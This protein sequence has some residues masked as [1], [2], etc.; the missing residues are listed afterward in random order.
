MDTG[1]IINKISIR[2]RRRSGKTGKKLGITEVQGKILGF[3]LVEGRERPLYQK[4][5]EKEFDL[6]PPTA[7]ELLKNLESLKMIKRVSSEE[8]GRYKKIQFTEAAEEIRLAMQQEI[9]N[10]EALLIK[11]ISREDLD[12]FMR[13]AEKMLENLDG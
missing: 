5:I 8:D 1:K 10:T 3:I 2:L 4:D 7:T 6:R 12:T 9:E 11:G 13:V